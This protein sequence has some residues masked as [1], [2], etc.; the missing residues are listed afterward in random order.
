M[1]FVSKIRRAAPVLAA[2]LALSLGACEGN[3]TG[4]GGSHPD[5]SA[6]RITLG[7]QTVTVNEAGAQTG[8][9][10]L[11]AGD[12]AVAVA[13]LN[14]SGAVIPSFSQVLTLQVVP[15]GT[16]T[17]VSFEAAGITGGRLTSTTPGAKTVTVR[18]LHGDHADFTQN[19][20]FTAL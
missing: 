18:L 14:A 9:L 7:A 3:S 6:V 4:S 17:G 2:V 10:T 12:N 5:V 8:S 20:T 15:V 16:G 11:P 1:L 19:L 13:W